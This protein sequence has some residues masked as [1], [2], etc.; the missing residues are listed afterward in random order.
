M[1]LL[2]FELGKPLFGV[3]RGNTAILVILFGDDYTQKK[4]TF[5]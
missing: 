3:K 4:P 1:I 2:N 5:P